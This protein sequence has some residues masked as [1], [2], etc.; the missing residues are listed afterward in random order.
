MLKGALEKLSE[1]MPNYD[2]FGGPDSIALPH[3]SRN[4]LWQKVVLSLQLKL[5]LSLYKGLGISQTWSFSQLKFSS[6]LP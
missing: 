1:E 6:T 3:V 2:T 4:C 5:V